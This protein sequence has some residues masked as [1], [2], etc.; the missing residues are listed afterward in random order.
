MF[1]NDQG[2]VSLNVT[3]DWYEDFN[4]V[5]ETLGPEDCIDEADMQLDNRYSVVNWDDETAE[6][7][8]K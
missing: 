6:V 4:E 8:T 3:D 1:T 7:Y 2:Q 5:L